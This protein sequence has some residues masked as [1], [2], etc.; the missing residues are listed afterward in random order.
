MLRV[1]DLFSGIG[2]FSLGLE[3][4]GGFRTVAFCEIDP[5]CRRV[6]GKHW[7]EVPVHE[8]ICAFDGADCDVVSAGYPCQPESLAGKRKGQADDR[9]LWPQAFRIVK[10]RR[11]AW[12]LGENVAGHASLGLDSVLS[13]LEG[14]GYTWRAFI[15]PACAV[16]APHR[17]DRLWIVAHS[18]SVGLQ[19]REHVTGAS[20]EAASG[21][22]ARSEADRVPTPQDASDTECWQR[23]LGGEAGR[24]GRFLESISGNGDWPVTSEPV[25]D[26]GADGIPNRL[27]RCRSLGNA[28]VPQIPEIIG[29]AI[30]EAEQ[31]FAQ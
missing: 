23:P 19:E 25:L 28:V 31:G 14:I 11:P 16:N 15:I 29:R 30:L 9:W 2:G 8:D 6:L 1:L 27:D 5:F 10:R 7:P 26:R 17:R 3:R 4:T 20:V 24:V 21:Q 13:D 12:F 22:H 18:G